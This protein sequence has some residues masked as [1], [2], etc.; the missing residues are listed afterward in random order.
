MWKNRSDFGIRQ[1][2]VAYLCCQAVHKYLPAYDHVFAA[3]AA[4]VQD[5]QFVFLA[6]NAACGEDLHRRL[7]RAFSAE[8][9]RASAHC[10]FLPPQLQA[11]FWNLNR[12]CDIYLDAMAWSG[13]NTA[14][15]AIACRL[16]VVTTP[17]RLMRGRHSY[18]ILTQIGVTDT[19]ASGV[20]E[21]VEIAVRLGRDRG[22]RAAIVERM[23]SRHASLFSDRRSAAAL[24]NWCREV[25]GR[26]TVPVSVPLAP[27]A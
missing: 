21:Y 4:R 12:V 19:I 20:E 5:A 26:Q 23:A 6:P 14:M 7:E 25:V 9:L 10:V 8:G 11:G 22:W 18:A 3:I 13:C 27:G 15:D 1:G 16:P 24:E 2:A 17:G